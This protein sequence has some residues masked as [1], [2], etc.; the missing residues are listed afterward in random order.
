MTGPDWPKSHDS[1]AD[2]VLEGLPRGR[3]GAFPKPCPSSG[4]SVHLLEQFGIEDPGFLVSFLVVLRP[5]AWGSSIVIMEPFG[6]IEGD[7]DVCRHTQISRASRLWDCRGGW[8][9]VLPGYCRSNPLLLVVVPSMAYQP[10]VSLA[11]ARISAEL[12]KMSP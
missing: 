10:V 4:V 5:P 8:S 6:F 2:Q 7:Y 11:V 1:H 9:V 3:A 12:R